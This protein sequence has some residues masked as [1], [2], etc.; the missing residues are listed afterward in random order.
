[1]FG[2]SAAAAAAIM[3]KFHWDYGAAR[4]KYRECD[5]DPFQFSA[6]MKVVSDLAEGVVVSDGT[7]T[8]FDEVKT[9]ILLASRS[10]VLLVNLRVGLALPR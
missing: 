8:V 3:K 4:K 5:D 1:M 9:Y 7:E 6:A 2:L 10:R